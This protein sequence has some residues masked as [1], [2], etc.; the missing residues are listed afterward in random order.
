MKDS[1]FKEYWEL[2]GFVDKYVQAK[3]EV[4]AEFDD[5]RKYLDDNEVVSFGSCWSPLGFVGTNVTYKDGRKE[6]M[7]GKSL[8]D[9]LKERS[10]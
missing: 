1:F 10:L 4:E 8:M 7:K 9:I 2:P 6:L 5:H 3:K